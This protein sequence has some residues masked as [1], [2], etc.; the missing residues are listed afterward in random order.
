MKNMKFNYIKDDIQIDFELPEGISK[1]I[2]I[3]EKL[4]QLND[5]EYLSYASTLKAT[6]RYY[7]D[8]GVLTK[9]Q[10]DILNKKYPAI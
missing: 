3:V 9:Q 7:V 2:A 1:I 5:G 8:K 10:Q 6:V 4:D